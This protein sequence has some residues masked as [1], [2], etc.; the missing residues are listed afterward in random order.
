MKSTPLFM[1]KPSVFSCKIDCSF[2]IKIPWVHETENR[3][4][5]SARRC[6]LQHVRLYA[7][8]SVGLFALDGRS[9]KRLRFSLL[10]ANSR[11]S[12]PGVAVLWRSV[13]LCKSQPPLPS[14]LSQ[15]QRGDN[16]MPA[17]G[18]CLPR[19]RERELERGAAALPLVMRFFRF[20]P[21]VAPSH[22]WEK[23]VRM[24]HGD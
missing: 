20:L 2:S 11:L 10:N 5:L 8:V 4:T 6:P 19:R 7:C 14:P 24:S 21:S 22:A 17:V 15:R 12:R 1:Q 3:T 23:D 13:Q 9:F 16:P 18:S